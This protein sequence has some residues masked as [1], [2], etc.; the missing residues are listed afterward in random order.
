VNLTVLSSI[1]VIHI[2]LGEA[3]VLFFTGPAFTTLFARIWLNEPISKLDGLSIIACLSGVILVARPTFL[4]GTDLQVVNSL[5]QT[6]KLTINK[7]VIAIA[8]ALV[9]AVM[10]A[11]AYVLV[12]KL[13]NRVHYMCHVVAFGIVSSIYSGCLL[14]VEW[15][16]DKNPIIQNPTLLQ[17]CILSGVGIVAFIGQVLLNFGLQLA[18]AGPG[19]LMRKYVLFYVFLTKHIPLTTTDYSEIAWMWYLL[20][21]L[22]FCSSMS[23]LTGRAI[24]EQH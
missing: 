12:R 10:S 18:P 5:H 4:F 17:W 8:A 13:G 6:V 16:A 3:T 15:M 23:T 11:L 19:V 20:L 21:L 9:G 1:S 7:R 14:W 24:L 22:G 2:D